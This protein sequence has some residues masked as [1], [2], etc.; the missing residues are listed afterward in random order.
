MDDLK[1]YA[2]EEAG[3]DTLIQT[4]RVFS[5]D[6]GMEFGI[7][8]CA[9]EIMKREKM[10][11]SNG[12]KLPQNDVIKALNAEEGYKYLGVLESDAIMK[13]KMKKKISK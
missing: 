1:I 4:V 7:E 9:V 2:K 8:K 3:L 12:I 11:N 10:S 13:I 5:S 6:I